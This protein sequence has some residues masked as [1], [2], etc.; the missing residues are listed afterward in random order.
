LELFREE[1]SPENSQ[2]TV[3]DPFCGTG[4]TG[5][6]CAKFGLK[7]LGSDK[8]KAVFNVAFRRVHDSF[9]KAGIVVVVI[10]V[11][12]DY[13]KFFFNFYRSCVGRHW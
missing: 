7:F 9:L 8:D 3:W 10:F 4:T 12:F 11:N 13:L 5:V 1:N 2:F 6:A